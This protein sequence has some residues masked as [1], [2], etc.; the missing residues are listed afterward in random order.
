VLKLSEYIT[1]NYAPTLNADDVINLFSI[2][3]EEYKT[4][5]KSTEKCDIT[6]RSYYELENRD[7]IQTNTK[8]KIL[9]TAYETSPHRVLDYLLKRFMDD[10]LEILYV[11]LVKIYEEAIE[12]V[13]IKLLKQI[14][15]EYNKIQKEYES[16]IVDNLQQE[17]QDQIIHLREKAKI[18]DINWDPI[19]PSLYKSNQLAFL[20]PLVFGELM[21]GEEPKKLSDRFSISKELVDALESIRRTESSINLIEYEG[22]IYGKT[23]KDDLI[24]YWNEP[25]SAA[26]T[27]E[28][29]ITLSRVEEKDEAQTSTA[30]IINTRTIKESY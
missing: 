26:S 5:K 27:P 22:L 13:D 16:L 15:E 6:R 11:N 8:E 1:S 18:E 10:S 25:S 21:R 23:S 24:D 19:K 3:R 14:L 12:E 9:K 4:I 20:L 17:V 7:Y 29:Y 2:I 30:Y 28:P